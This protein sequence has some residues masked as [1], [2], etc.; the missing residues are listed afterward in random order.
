MFGISS[1]EDLDKVIQD[2]P[3][4]FIN[5]LSGALLLI[6]NQLKGVAEFGGGVWSGM[7]PEQQETVKQAIIKLIVASAEA[8][9][10]GKA[11]F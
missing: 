1:K 6:P 4:N 2:A 9:V 11:E 5:G 8:Y 3:K 7:T 10:K